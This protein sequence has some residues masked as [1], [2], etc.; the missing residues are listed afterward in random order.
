MQGI[1]G[2]YVTDKAGL[3]DVIRYPFSLAFDFLCVLCVLCGQ[4]LF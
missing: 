1:K 2:D 4:F 3:R